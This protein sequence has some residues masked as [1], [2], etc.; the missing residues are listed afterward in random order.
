MDKQHKLVILGDS[1]FAQV[2]FEYF[3]Y[4][5]PYEVVAFSIDQA[6]IKRDSL[7]GLPIVP[8]EQLEQHYSPAEHNFYAAFIYTQLNRLRTRFYRA[9]KDKGY[10]P[11][12]YVSQ[13]AFVWR[14]AQLGEHCFIFEDNVIQP[15]VRIGNNV[16]LWS[17]NH[18][19]HHSS[20]GDNTFLASHVVVSGF[21]EMGQSCFAGVNVSIGNNVTIGNDCLLG[22]S[23][24]IVHDIPEN[25]LVKSSPSEISASRTARQFF[26]VSE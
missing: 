12:S 3:Q 21:V 18:I 4:D 14:N 23:A 1:A 13:R 10:R 24:T 7:F 25:S 15:F 16:V 2:A 19:G 9:A 17:G 11:A 20:I 8:F 5:S 6:Y 26:K 22:A